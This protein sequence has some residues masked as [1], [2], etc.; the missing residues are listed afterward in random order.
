MSRETGLMFGAICVS[1]FVI[2]LVFTIKA[3]V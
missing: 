3:V 2:W 1:L